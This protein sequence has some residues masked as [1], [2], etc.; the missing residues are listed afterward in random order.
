MFLHQKDY[1][2]SRL[3]INSAIPTVLVEPVQQ[4]PCPARVDAVSALS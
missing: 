4:L 3:G 1:I 2:F